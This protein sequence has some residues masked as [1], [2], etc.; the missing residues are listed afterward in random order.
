MING[1]L[2]TEGTIQLCK[3]GAWG[4][5]C[6]DRFGHPEAQVVCRKLG[7]TDGQSY[8]LLQIYISVLITT[9]AGLDIHVKF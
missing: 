9:H 3:D 7:L 5:V 2:P 8:L 4:L 6:D 1:K